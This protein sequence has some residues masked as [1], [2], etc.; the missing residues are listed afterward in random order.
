MNKIVIG[1]D[2]PGCVISVNHYKYKYYTKPEAKAWMETLGWLVKAAIAKGNHP[3]LSEWKLPLTV[4]CDGTFIDKRSTPDLSNLSK[5]IMDAIQEV[6]VNDR[7]FR[8]KDGD[9][10]YGKEARLT[11]A[12]QEST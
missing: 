7:Y 12:I 6:S 5:V 8:W 11:I 4:R 9:I 2:Y 3:P 1:I 10:S